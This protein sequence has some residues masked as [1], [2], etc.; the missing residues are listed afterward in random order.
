MIDVGDQPDSV[1]SVFA[2][3]P[4]ALQIALFAPFPTTWLDKMSV[5]RLAGIAETLLWYLIVPGVIFAIRGGRSLK[6]LLLIIYAALFL[7]V[8]GFAN[9]NVG[10]LFRMRYA[11]LFLFVL[12][13][14]LGWTHWWL[15]RRTGRLPSP[16]PLLSGDAAV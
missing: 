5:I 2:Y 11:Y 13:G 6:M 9:P 12:V 4:R 10:T 7:T 3:L 14:T 15:S 16:E 1:P 8:L